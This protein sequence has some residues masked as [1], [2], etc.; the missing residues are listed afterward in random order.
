MSPDEEKV[1]QS[2]Q[3]KDRQAFQQ[4]YLDNYRSFLLVAYKY[5]RDQGKALEVVNDVFV[6]IW[7]AA[8]TITIQTSLRS[9]LHRAV[10][11]RSLN[12]VLKDKKD[13]QRLQ[14]FNQLPQDLIEPRE[15]EENELK[16]KLYKEIDQL[17]EQCKKVFKLSRFEGKKKHEIA[18]ELGISVK[19]VKNH[20]N[21]A[22]KSLNKVLTDWK[23]IQIFILLTNCCVFCPHG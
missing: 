20:L 17:P 1:W 9:Y 10:I 12:V 16:L 2:I 23:S 8:E 4:F 18:E 19:T 6:I 22:L 13:K 7:E 15:M 14:E 3:Q 11:N 21:R 5:L